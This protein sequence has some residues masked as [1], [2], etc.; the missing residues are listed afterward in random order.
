MTGHSERLGRWFLGLGFED[1]P[2]DVVANTKLH[3]LDAIGLAL[4]VG[5][6]RYGKVVRGSAL[7]MGR[8]DDSRILGF[9]DRVPAALAALANGTMAGE[10][11]FSDT[12]NETHLHPEAVVVATALAAGELTGAG[13]KEVLTTV[14]AGNEVGCRLSLVAPGGLVRGGFHTSGV[15]GALA[16]AFMAGRFLGLDEDGMRNAVG[17]AGSQASGILQCFADGSWT[18]ALHFGWAAH[19]GI[20]AAHL[21]R[22][23]FVGP[24]EVL[25]GRWGLFRTHIQGQDATFDFERMLAD[26]GRHWENRFI[27]IKLYPTGCVIHP[28]LDAILHLHREAG[29]NADQVKCITMP[30]SPHWIGLV[31][32]PVAEK[33]HPKSEQDARVSLNYTLAEALTLGCLDVD[34][35]A[36]DSIADPDILALAAKMRYVV[37]EDPPPR[38]TFNGRVIVET[39]DGRTLER[40]EDPWNKG[41]HDNPETPEHVCA[42]FRQNVAG[43]L[44]DGR[45]EAIIDAV[46]GLDEMTDIGQLVELC[47]L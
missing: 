2:P 3:I 25:E 19:N 35:F 21:A 31:C 8:G 11:D 6:K 47:V 39:T 45:A 10:L 26:L 43:A 4:L 41:H 5:T 1:L 28:Y 40:T 36:A 16:A 22:A 42:K 15:I 37:D 29:L 17:I 30:V 18:K 13:G 33:L 20:V 23:G 7:N 9:G 32:E 46:A 12:H 24:A 27:S 34:S 14:A 44:P 38:K